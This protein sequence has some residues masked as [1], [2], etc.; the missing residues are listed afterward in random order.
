MSELDD[1]LRQFAG[2][3]IPSGCDYCNAD[4]LLEELSPGMH[5][6]TVRHDDDCPVLRASRSRR[7]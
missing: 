6:L 3:P 4:Q 2:E 5:V 7:N 1:L